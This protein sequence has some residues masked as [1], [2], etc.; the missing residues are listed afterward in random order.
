MSVLLTGLDLTLEEVVRV[1]RGGEPVEL[2]PAAIERMRASRDVVESA[3]ARGD[4]I[5]GFS[6][7]VGMRKLFAIE[8]DQA[9]FNRMLIRGHLIAPG[10]C[11]AG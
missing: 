1:A 7:G 11:R 5:Y 8:D 2:A 4:S 6:T 3:L 10:P 9:H